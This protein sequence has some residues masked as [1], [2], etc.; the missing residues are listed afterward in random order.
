VVKDKVVIITGAGKGIGRY[1]AGTFVTA[2]AKVV[3]SDIDAPAL[4]RTV[5]E[6]TSADGD[7]LG[8]ETDVRDEAQVEAMVARAI[9]RFGRIDVLINN[10]AVVTHSHLWP[11][12]TWTQPWPVVRDMSKEFWDRVIETNLTGTFL[13]SKHVIPHMEAQGGGHIITLPGGGAATKLGV[14]AYSI[15]KQAVTVFARFLAEEVRAANICVIA[16]SPGAT[17]GT[18]DAPEEVFRSY[19]GVEVVGQ[20]YVLAADAPMELS[21]HSLRLVEGRLEAAD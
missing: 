4:Q 11:A 21:G 17:I 1:V 8:I 18:E 13:C 5:A 14:L 16:I 9:E 15:T 2:G 3:A 7:V 10:A 20:R 12:P 19:P 6:L